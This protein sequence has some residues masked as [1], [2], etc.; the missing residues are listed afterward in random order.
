MFLDPQTRRNLELLEGSGGTRQSL[1]GGRA[2][3]DAYANGRPAAACSGS[4]SHCLTLRGWK[5]ARMAWR[6]SPM[7]HWCGRL[8][9]KSLSRLATWSA[10]STVWCRAS[11]WPRRATGCGCARACAP[12][13][14]GR[15][16]GWMDAAGQAIGDRPQEIGDTGQATGDPDEWW[17][18][19]MVPGR[20]ARHPLAPNPQPPTPQ[21]CVSSARPSVKS[22]RGTMKMI[23]SARATGMISQQ[24][25]SNERRATSDGL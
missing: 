10:P 13:R 4:R 25:T 12:C 22:R 16:A 7:M 1:A 11:P 18:E 2:G 24:R 9:A 23:C 20:M 17:A 19:M 15:G 3:S 21:A 5:R 14:A 6:T 8:C